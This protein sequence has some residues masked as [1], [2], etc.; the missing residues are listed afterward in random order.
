MSPLSQLTKL[1]KGFPIQVCALIPFRC[2]LMLEWFD[3]KELEILDSL[4]ADSEVVLT[5][6]GG[7]PKEKDGEK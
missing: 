1:L 7:R 3:G 5:S 2:A 4:T 6:L